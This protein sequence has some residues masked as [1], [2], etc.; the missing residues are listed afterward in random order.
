MIGR[1]KEL[2]N[3]LFLF[4]FLS[5]TLFVNFFHTEKT[6]KESYSCAA[7][8]FQSSSLTTATINF[9]QPPQLCFLELLKILEVFNDRQIFPVN[10]SPRGPP[11]A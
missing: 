6:V 10:V 8:L 2:F 9:F 7:C 1:K 5:V 3:L 11:Q 4:F